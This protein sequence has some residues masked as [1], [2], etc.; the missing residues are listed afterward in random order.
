MGRK[1]KNTRRENKSAKQETKNPN[2]IV[3]WLQTEHQKDRIRIK[4]IPFLF[5]YTFLFL[6]FLKIVL[7][8][9]SYFDECNFTDLQRIGSVWISFGI[10]LFF[11]FPILDKIDNKIAIGGME[12]LIEMGAYKEDEH[13]EKARER[14]DFLKDPAYLKRQVLYV[15]EITMVIFGTMLS[16]YADVIDS[17]LPIFKC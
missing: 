14:I 7:V 4:R 12:K 11:I 2:K 16:G 5:I 6:A 1:N 9:N 17:Y 10:F 8:T 13:V 3:H 15:G